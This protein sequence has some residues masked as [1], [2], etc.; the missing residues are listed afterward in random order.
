MVPALEGLTVS[1][2]SRQMNSHNTVWEV[3]HLRYTHEEELLPLFLKSLTD[4]A[5]IT[6]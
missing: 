2:G 6:N 5:D 1:E 3:L 4:V